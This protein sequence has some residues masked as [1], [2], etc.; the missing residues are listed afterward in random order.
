MRNGL[1]A[2]LAFSLAVV[3]LITTAS[4]ASASEAIGRLAPMPSTSCVGSTFD[5][6][7]PTVTSG[8]GYVVQPL[9][10]VDALMIS[11]WSHNAAPAPPAGALTFKVFRKTADP[12][13]YTVVGHDGP[14]E[15]TAG[16]LNT[17]PTS[18]PVQ[19]GDVIGINSAMPAATACTFFDMTE[20]P[21]G[22]SG[23]LADGDSGPFSAFDE[24]DVNVSAVVSPSNAFTLGA[25]RLQKRRGTATLDATV[26]NPGELAVDGKGIREPMTSV[27]SPSTIRFQIQAKGPKRS[28]LKKHGKVKVTP[29]I[30]YTPTGGEAS[31]QSA[32]VK[33]RLTR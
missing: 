28:K 26:P 5:I 24:K 1:R 33:L 2:G 27:A 20:T 29:T 16:A 15:L 10:N 13:T 3:S 14:H 6:I 7:E 23:N 9:P 21:L 12:A 22:R 17:F 8:T 30:T 32:T 19:P 31:I 18:I 25:A 4:V 11:S